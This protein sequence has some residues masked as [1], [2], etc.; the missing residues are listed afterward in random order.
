MWFTLLGARYFCDPTSIIQ[1]CFGIPWIYWKQFDPFDVCF[2]DLLS[3]SGAGFI[4][5]PEGRPSWV[6]FPMPWELR[7]FF[8]RGSWEQALCRHHALLTNLLGRF[9]LILPQVVSSYALSVLWWIFKENPLQISR[10]LSLCVT[11]SSLVLCPMDS[12][13]LALPRL[14]APS[15]QLREHASLLLGLLPTAFLHCSRETYQ[16]ECWSDHRAHLTCFLSIKAHFF[17]LPDVQ[18]LKRCYFIYFF[19]FLVVTGRRVNLARVTPSLAGTEIHCP[20]CKIIAC[21]KVLLI[22]FA[23]SIQTDLHCRTSGISYCLSV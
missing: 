13:C 14:S 4:I 6:S 22:H 5:T 23:F 11:L 17:S 1:R 12:N 20:F 7:K 16:A 21:G 10:I 2:Y 9:F 3:R 19:W 8:Q 18:C 15:L